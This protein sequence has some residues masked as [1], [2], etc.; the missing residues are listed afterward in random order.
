M[1]VLIG[2]FM[3]CFIVNWHGICYINSQERI[4]KNLYNLDEEI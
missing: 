4:K 3:K 1:L 2:S